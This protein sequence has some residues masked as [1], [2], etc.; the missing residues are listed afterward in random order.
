MATAWLPRLR[1]AVTSLPG[2]RRQ[3]GAV[4]D[5][6]KEAPEERGVRR[7]DWVA[8]GWRCLPGGCERRAQ[9][10][11]SGGGWD[12]RCHL[13]EPARTR[14]PPSQVL[15][16]LPLLG[17]AG[18]S[19]PALRPAGAKSGPHPPGR[20]AAR[21]PPSR[22]PCA[23]RAPLTRVSAAL[24]RPHLPRWSRQI[25]PLGARAPFPEVPPE[26]SLHSSH[27]TSSP[28][29]WRWAAWRLPLALDHSLFLICWTVPC[30][31]GG[32]TGVWDL[33]LGFPER[34]I[35]DM[36][37]QLVLP[38]LVHLLVGSGRLRKMLVSWRSAKT[39]PG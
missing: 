12:T 27:T 29:S 20:A 3:S 23:P 22:A 11:G 6:Q 1:P 37:V 34:L 35:L 9:V 28:S 19:G 30:H 25:A 15:G 8:E 7:R 31:G 39:L 5:K 26:C 21:E 32:N 33:R 4:R 17:G 14:A 13:T 38:C 36:K 16:G 2:R 10:S 18:H 24:L